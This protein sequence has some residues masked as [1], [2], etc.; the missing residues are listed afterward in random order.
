MGVIFHVPMKSHQ[1]DPNTYHHGTLSKDSLS[2]YVVDGSLL[3]KAASD[4]V[5]VYVDG[6]HAYLT[7][8]PECRRVACAKY[9]VRD[10]FKQI[11]NERSNLYVM[12]EGTTKFRYQVLVDLK[13]ANLELLDGYITR[14]SL[15]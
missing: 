10:G 7:Y 13:N 4:G 11:P 14:S 12:L 9:E 6:A 5:L 15:I 8:D 3:K 1:L 2:K